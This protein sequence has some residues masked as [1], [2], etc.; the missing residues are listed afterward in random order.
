MA[1]QTSSVAT[2]GN[3]TKVETEY[4]LGAEARRTYDMY[5]TPLKNTFEPRG[6]TTQVQ[7]ATPLVPRPTTALGSETS[8]FDPQTWRDTT[9]TI[10]K[11]YIAD[12]FKRHIL[13][14]LKSSLNVAATNEMLVGRLAMET[15]E[16]IARRAATEGGLVTYG[17][18]AAGHNTRNTLDLGT[19][20][21]NLTWNNFT[22]AF[23]YLQNWEHGNGPLM[24]TITPFQYADLIGTGTGNLFTNSAGYT[25]R[26]ITILSKFE[27][28]MAAG[29]RII[30]SPLAKRLYGAGAANASAVSTTIATSTTANLA[31]ARTIEVAANT[32]IVA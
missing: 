21:D 8:D 20:T 14:E 10:T 31:G 24:A 27:V 16:A 28:G 7:W 26:G 11:V 18:M 15:I 12:G 1:I 32:N 25:E 5:A 2:A 9:A 6:A 3:L 13:Q 17:N 29:F 23:T 22:T 4:R 19:A 30:R